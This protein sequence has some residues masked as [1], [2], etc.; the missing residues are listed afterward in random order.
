MKEKNKDI[1]L[2]GIDEQSRK[3]FS[4]GSFVW[5]KSNEDIWNDMEKA[6]EVGSFSEI[7]RKSNKYSILAIAAGIAILI[8]ITGFMRFYTKNITTIPGTHLM[9]MLPDKST[10]NLNAESF[11]SFKPYWWRFSRQVKFEGEGLFEVEKG[12]KFTVFS[13]LGSTTVVGTS[14]NIFSRDEV[15]RV[16]CIS[17]KV[18]VASK[19]NEEV[20]LN[21]DT[22]ALVQPDGRIDVFKNIE[23]I[24]E[25]SWKNNIFLFTASPINEVF[26]EIERQYGVTIKA[27][28]DNYILYTG[29]FT[30]NQNVEEILSYICPALGY[31][32]IRESNKVYQIIPND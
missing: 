31:K 7:K 18:R 21:P 3:I 30:K 26:K 29:N 32:Y 14:F 13:K 22:K 5:K 2:S 15:Y 16:T 10:V 17:G 1:R 4:G 6:I 12:K 28:I 27:N 8:G 19:E 9:V 24:P 20:L 25:I 11:I 23:T